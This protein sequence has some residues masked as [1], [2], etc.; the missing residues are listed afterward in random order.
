MIKHLLSFIGGL[1]LTTLLY[2]LI[3]F[4]ILLGTFSLSGETLSQKEG[5]E[6]FFFYTA[7]VITATTIYFVCRFLRQRRKFTAAGVA[8]PLLAALYTVFTLGQVYIHHF[9]Y[10]QSFT[11]TV[12]RQSKL[13][14]FKMAKTLAKSD[15]LIGLSRQAVVEKLGTASDSTKTPLLDVMRY[16]TDSSSWQ[17]RVYFTKSKVSSVDIYQEGL[18][19]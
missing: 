13:K 2:A 16:R 1:A 3:A 7:L 5:R 6:A 14:P 10:R 9:N 12:W 15:A 17:M 18:N 4:L 8:V 19:L 11:N